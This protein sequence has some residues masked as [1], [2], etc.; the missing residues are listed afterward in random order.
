MR[1]PYRE[2]DKNSTL[3]PSR[4]SKEVI[5][6]LYG[7][8]VWFLGAYTVSSMKA[9]SSGLTNLRPILGTC[10]QSIPDSATSYLCDLEVGLTTASQQ[11]GAVA[12]K[13][14]AIEGGKLEEREAHPFLIIWPAQTTKV[15]RVH[16]EES[17]TAV[18]HPAVGF[19]SAALCAAVPEIRRHRRN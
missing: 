10:T 19:R 4:G 14:S 3:S 15:I 12:E 8:L 6:M 1:K 5:F 18:D 17:V 16:S 11:G 7:G 9:M 13:K 2:W